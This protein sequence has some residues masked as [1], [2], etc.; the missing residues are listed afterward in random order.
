VTNSFVEQPLRVRIEALMSAGAYDDPKAIVLADFSGP[1]AAEWKSNS[2]AGVTFSLG[3]GPAAA[4]LVATSAG[5]VP[6]NAAWARLE[7]KFTPPLNLKEHQALGLWIE[8]DGL[9]ELVALRLESPQHLAFGAVADRY[10]AVDFTGR[11][12]VTLVE[13]ESERWSDYVWNDG[14][15]AYNTY[16]E[17]IDFGAVESAS[18][19]CQNLP[20]GRETQCRLGPIKALPMVAGTLKDPALAINGTTLVFPVEIASGGWLECTSVDDCALYDAKGAL[21]KKVTPRGV[22]PRLRAGQNDAIFS[23]TLAEGPS[24]RAK[25]TIFCRG[26]EL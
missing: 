20:P 6:R 5:Q 13:T 22:L 25:V 23:C 18:V 26:D 9:G 15:S 3:A 1:T 17:T 4:A 8:G 19:W 24:P 2:A 14:K 16:R 7:K 21:V 11:R 10:L 12:L